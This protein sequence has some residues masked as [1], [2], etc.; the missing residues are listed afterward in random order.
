MAANPR[1]RLGEMLLAEGL[2]NKEQLD[3]A[4]EICALESSFLGQ[5]LVE[6]DYLTEDQL[7]AVL[8][9]QCRIPHIS[10]TDYDID[11]EE[12]TRFNC[13]DIGLAPAYWQPLPTLP[14]QIIGDLTS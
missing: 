10:L 2:V 6:L 7:M 11:R 8:V 3:E 13:R 9:R 14:E 12:W 4:L 1:S 5:A